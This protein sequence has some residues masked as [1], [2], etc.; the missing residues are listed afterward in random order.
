MSEDK[1]VWTLHLEGGLTFGVSEGVNLEVGGRY[2]RTEAP[3][4]IIDGTQDAYIAFEEAEE[5]G[6]FVGLTAQF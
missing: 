5:M 2:R 4:V 6:G 1:T 3:Q